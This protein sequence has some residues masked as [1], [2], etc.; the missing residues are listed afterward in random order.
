MIQPL[1]LVQSFTIL[2]RASSLDL[3]TACDVVVSQ[4]LMSGHLQSAA[5]TIPNPREKLMKV[6]HTHL[7]SHLASGHELWQVG[8]REA[9][10]GVI[11]VRAKIRGLKIRTFGEWLEK[12][13]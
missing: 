8:W 1:R 3:S 7:A 11:Y 10:K 2:V 13:W 4:R 12:L 9:H 5:V 6:N